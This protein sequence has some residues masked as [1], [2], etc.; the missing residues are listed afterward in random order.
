[1]KLLVATFL[2]LNINTAWAHPGHPDNAFIF[3]GIATAMILLLKPMFR[4][5]K[6]KYK[7]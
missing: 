1:M 3:A 2:L 6:A 7:R 5:V 4:L